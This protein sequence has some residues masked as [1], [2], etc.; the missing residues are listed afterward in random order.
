MQISLRRTAI[1]VAA[2]LSTYSIYSG[3]EDQSRVRSRGNNLDNNIFAVADHGHVSTLL[4]GLP[5][6]S[7]EVAVVQSR[8]PSVMDGAT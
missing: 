2:A 5:L 7:H 1:G 3:G 6:E 8:R 4:S